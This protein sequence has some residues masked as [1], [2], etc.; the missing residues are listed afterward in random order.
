MLDLQ[1]EALYI[2]NDRIFT[3]FVEWT[4]AVLQA[5]GVPGPAL[6]VGLRLV[7]DQ[8]PDFPTALSYLDSGLARLDA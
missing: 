3:D 7:R 1:A 4:A 5:R 6:A 8:L 2:G